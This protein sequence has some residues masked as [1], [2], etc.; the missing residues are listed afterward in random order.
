[1][2]LPVAVV[3][4]R[5]ELILDAEDDVAAASTIA[6]VR[7]ATRDVGLAAERDHA[8][9]AV[10]AADQ[11]ARAIEEHSDPRKRAHERADPQMRQLLA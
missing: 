3:A 2:R 1:M 10:A 6:A 9:A 4:E 11:D 5:S 8:L 7:S